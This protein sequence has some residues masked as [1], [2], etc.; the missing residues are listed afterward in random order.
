MN[1]PNYNDPK[2]LS[3]SSHQEAIEHLAEFVL[4]SLEEGEYADWEPFEVYAKKLRSRI[5]EDNLI[6]K[7]DFIK[8]YEALLDVL[9]LMNK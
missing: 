7:R 1:H 5:H 8:G 3:S 4:E 2:P 9:N 6:F